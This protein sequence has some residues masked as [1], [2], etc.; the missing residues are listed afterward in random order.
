M[1]IGDY[2]LTG[3]CHACTLVS[4]QGAIDWACLTR[5]DAGSVAC[6]GN[7]VPG[8]TRLEAR[9]TFAEGRPSGHTARGKHDSSGGA[10]RLIRGLGPASGITACRPGAVGLREGRVGGEE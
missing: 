3:D 7:T 8:F 9:P 2:A 10:P 4:K 6:A 5:F 1:P